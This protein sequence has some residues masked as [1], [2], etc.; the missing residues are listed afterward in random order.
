MSNTEIVSYSQTDGIAT[1]AMDDGK[2][3]A[4]ST[5]MVKQL[6][7]AFDRAAA[8]A[9]GVVVVGREGKFCAGFDLREMMAGPDSALALVKRGGELLM[10]IYDFPMPVV[11]ACSG[12]AMAGGALLVATG[13]TRLGAQGAFKIGLN[14]VQVSMPVPILAHELARDR[15]LPTELFASVVQAKI[16]DPDGAARAGWLD[17]VVAPEKLLDEARAVARELMKLPARAYAM[18]KHSLRRGTIKHIRD[19]LESNVA[20]LMPK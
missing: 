19:T 10:R 9:K 16:Y 3:N 20:E 7:Q 18:S 11:I 17:R 1:I 13:D 15:L 5:E 6:E 2:A 4:L 12:H 8:E 14:E